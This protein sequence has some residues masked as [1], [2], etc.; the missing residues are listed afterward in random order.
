M[1]TTFVASVALALLACLDT[2]FAASTESV[3]RNFR[4]GNDGANP[5]G[6]VIAD[7]SGAL[8]GVT[9][10]GGGSGCS[11]AGC[12][13]AFELT[14]SNAY[15]VLHHFRGGAGDGA[16]PVGSLLLDKSS[17]ALYGVTGEGGSG[18]CGSDNLG[19]GTVFKL[20]PPPEGETRWIETIIH[21]FTGGC[22]T[23]DGGSPSAPAQIILHRPPNHAPHTPP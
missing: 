21:N 2:A 22:C 18:V 15:S 14:A 19:C 10:N 12:G 16:K 7:A 9:T 8:Y 4:S 11:G 20:A 13:T 3:L 17:G 6:G 23:G 5:A 1:R